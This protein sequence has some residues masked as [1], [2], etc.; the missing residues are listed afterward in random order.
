MSST[1]T[2]SVFSISAR[3]LDA[4]CGTGL[5]GEALRYHGFSNLSGVDLTQA[6]L[7]LAQRKQVY[8]Q[9][10]TV[11]LAQ[12]LPFPDAAYDVICSAGVFSHGPVL[13]EHMSLFLAPLVDGGLCVHTIIG[14]AYEKIPYRKTLEE[15]DNRGEIELIE[16]KPIPYTVGA[17]VPRRLITFRKGLPA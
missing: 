10:Q 16:D 14:L 11:D 17:G 5:C 2:S 3:I 4:G 12:P 9:L 15:M 8:R 1:G 6:M 13:P 7:D